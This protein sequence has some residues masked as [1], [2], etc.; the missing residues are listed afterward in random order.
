M[1][2]TLADGD[3]IKPLEFFAQGTQSPF[4]TSHSRG[5]A[6]RNGN[7]TLSQF[8]GETED[9]LCECDMCHTDALVKF[10]GDATVKELV[11]QW[12][13]ISQELFELVEKVKNAITQGSVAD[14]QIGMIAIIYD[15][16]VT[17]RMTFLLNDPSA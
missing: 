5:Q 3:T 1:T 15:L 8:I 2:Y 16:L 14:D 10:P 7:I 13:L 6:L 4:E 17:R 12:S 9:L 11:L